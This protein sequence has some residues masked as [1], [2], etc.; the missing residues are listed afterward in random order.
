MS[1][2]KNSNVKKIIVRGA[3]E[4]N[5]KNLSFELPR[6]KLIVF[7]GVSGSGKSSLVFDTIYAEGQRRYV[8]SLSSYARQFLERMNKPDVEFIQGISPAVAIEQKSGSRNPRSTVGTTTEIYDYLRLLFARIGKTI[9]FQCGKE[10]NKA[11]TGTVVDW[12]E[13]QPEGTKFYLTFPLHIH[14]GTTVKQ[15]I[16]LLKRRGFFRIFFNGSLHDMNVE[17]LLP[18]RKEEIRVVID[19]FKINKGELRERLADAIEV[20]FKEGEDRLVLIN[21]DTG[22][23]TEFNKFYECCGIRYEEPE[24]RFFSFN[25]PFGACPVCQGF[26]K[27]IGI[28]MNLVVPNPNLTIADGAIAPWRSAKY[29]TYLRDLIKNAKQYNIPLNVPFKDLSDEQIEKIQKGFGDFIGIDKFFEKLESKTYKMHVRVFLSRYRGYSTCRACKGSR[30]R[31]EALQVKID[32]HS[33]YD[34]V[35]LQIEKALQFFLNLRLSDYDSHVGDRILKE[36]IKRLTFLNNVG[37][38]Y[39]TLDRLSSTLSGGE[40]QRINLA[41]SLGSALVGTLYVLDEPSIGL[42]PKDNIKLINILK[43][44]RDIGNTVLVVEHDPEMMKHADLLVDMGPKAGINGGEIVAMGSYDE[45]VKNKNSL[46]GKYLS[47]K[48]KIPLPAKRNVQRTKSL[49]IIGASENNLK[50]IDVEIPLNKFVVVTG[51]SGSGKSTLVHDVL[52]GGLAKYFGLA[53]AKVGKCNDIIGSEYID[54]VEIVDQSP[55][56]KTPRSNPIS[57]IKAFELIRELFASTPQAKARGYK[58]GY[59]SFNV[60]GG[61]CETCQG[62]GFIKVEMQFLADLYLECED[63]KGTRFKE[64]IREIFYRDKNLV[65]VLNMTVDESIEFFRNEPKILRQIKLL[66]DVGLGYIKLGQPSNTLSGGE[67]Q[68]VKLAAHLSL[69]REHKHTLFIFDEP[70][71]GL[72]FDDISKL[73][74][75]FNL[76]IEKGNSLVV[77]E[78]NLEVIKCADYV[79]DLGPEAGDNGGKVIAQGTPEEI[80]KNKNSYTGLY[81]KQYLT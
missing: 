79:I 12:L 48:L 69:Q 34:I 41:T 55:I 15:E 80:V 47:G 73:L 56:G 49:K 50:N 21:A 26:S 37:I 61:R 23:Q 76:L 67:A 58:P 54:E 29:G 9:C 2:T 44:L 1:K 17:D 52:Y 77:I 11:S 64:E 51:V 18:K 28:D 13:Q 71:T 43:N 70:T 53:P 60:P 59:F 63:C 38:G 22:E 7:T 81:L 78:H 36:I 42:H 32:N 66:A 45:I 16:E 10:V 14:E 8:E 31:R 24:P 4:H 27:T 6:N 68:R 75:C 65:D 39:L 46:T 19:R 72:H 40:A 35:Q 57:Y 3:K 74:N 5:L 30:L 20:T 62:D 33:I 25:N